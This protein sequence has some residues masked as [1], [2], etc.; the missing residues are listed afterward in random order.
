MNCLAF[1]D[2]NGVEGATNNQVYFYANDTQGSK[3]VSPANQLI[4]ASISFANNNE[5]EVKI[6]LKAL[7]GNQYRW[8]GMGYVKLYKV[9]AVEIAI[10]EGESYTPANVAGT[11]TLLRALSTEKWNSFVVPFQ[12]SN[13][14]L[15]TAF[16]IG[17]Q[18]A[19]YT[20]EAVGENSTISFIPMET[21]AIA[22]N[23]P[24]LLKPSTVTNNNTYVFE[25]R[26]IS[27]SE[28]KVEG[29][30]FDFVGTYAATSTI[31][32]G[33]YFIGTSKT[34]GKSKLFQSTGTTT[35]KGTRA[36]LKAKS[37]NA[38]ITNFIFDEDA[39]VISGVKMAGDSGK[40]YNLNGQEVKS[41]RKGIF[42]QDGK[43][44]V[45]K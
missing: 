17:V 11:V 45:V 22:A 13:A 6:G 2:A 23:K 24:V 34:D 25:N 37:A 41:T 28:A 12:I 40:I 35:I 10:N 43:K 36:Y 33:D 30:N 42:I 4:E 18:V 1:A 44:I 9:P 19:E 38:R 7:T 39:T 5:Q 14:E 32:A 26:D 16:G 27:T 8:M 31:A 20:E 21:P 29:T 3:I 15:K